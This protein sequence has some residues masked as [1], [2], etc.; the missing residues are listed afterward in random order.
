MSSQAASLWRNQL[1]RKISNSLGL[2]ESEEISVLKLKAEAFRSLRKK[3][4]VEAFD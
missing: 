3:L 4:L 2:P 1:Y